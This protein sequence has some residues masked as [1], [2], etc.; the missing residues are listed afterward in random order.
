MD[1]G[2]HRPYADLRAELDEIWHVLGTLTKMINTLS[3]EEQRKV[4]DRWQA[5]H[6]RRPTTTTD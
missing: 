2:D 3:D 6:E 4:L 1:D 5:E